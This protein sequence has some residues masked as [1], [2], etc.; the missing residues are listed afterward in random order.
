MTHKTKETFFLYVC[1]WWW[2]QQP[3]QIPFF[4]YSAL[5]PWDTASCISAGFYNIHFRT[6][7][8]HLTTSQSFRVY[9]LSFNPLNPHRKKEKQ[10]HSIRNI[11]RKRKS[12]R[13]R[14]DD[15][16]LI[17]SIL[18]YC[19][20]IQN[21]HLAAQLLSPSPKYKLLSFFLSLLLS[22]FKTPLSLLGK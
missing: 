20:R 14:I 16:H 11:T 4:F 3:D 1:C 10:N 9:W 6:S 22:Q 17:Y 18:S 12:M 15:S 13:S 19:K 8:S 7:L 5:P 2:R 21:I